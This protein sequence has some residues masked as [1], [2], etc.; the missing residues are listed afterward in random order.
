MKEREVYMEQVITILDAS[1][2]LGVSKTT[3]TR[4]VEALGLK[5]NKSGNRYVLTAEQFDMIRADLIQRGRT[6][7][8][9]VAPH[10]SAPARTRRTGA[11]RTCRASGRDGRAGERA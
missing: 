7:E 1:N 10:T 4:T 3:I 8:D 6:S 5:L 2:A 9:P 11:G